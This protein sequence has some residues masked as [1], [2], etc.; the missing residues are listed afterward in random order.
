MAAPLESASTSRLDPELLP[1]LR[2]LLRGD[3]FAVAF[4][5]SNVPVESKRIARTLIERLT[6]EGRRGRI[7]HLHEPRVDL[8]GEILG[9]EPP[10]E[11]NEALFVLGFERSIPA[12]TEIAGAPRG[13]GAMTPIG[14]VRSA[15]VPTTRHGVSLARC[16][17]PAAP[18]P[19]REL[20]LGG[21]APPHVAGRAPDRR[22]RV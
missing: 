4:V 18:G 16:T 17:A 10:Q 12:S 9:L 22:G 3:A 15:A 21:R 14:R 20:G 19:P 5:R 1:L 6:A 7:L 13:V 2:L 8:L 11:H